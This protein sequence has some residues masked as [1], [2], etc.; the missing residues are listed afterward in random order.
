MGGGEV[1]AGAS[2]SPAACSLRCRKMENWSEESRHGLCILLT[3]RAASPARRCTGASPRRV[4]LDG[5]PLPLD[6]IAAAYPEPNQPGALSAS[7]AAAAGIS[8]DSGVT[9]TIGS[10]DCGGLESA[11]E[12]VATPSPSPV[13]AA[14]PAPRRAPSAERRRSTRTAGGHKAGDYTA[15]GGTA[16]GV[17]F[18]AAATVNVTG[19][20]EG[21]VSR[22]RNMLQTSG[23]NKF[24]YG[25]W[26]NV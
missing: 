7:A 26:S 20:A 8:R 12:P 22:R 14:R 5:A 2:T 15:A 18:M 19:D 11:P 24:Y 6:R 25:Q 10:L 23:S 1:R 13:P 21:I 9:A 3:W 16:L 4:Q 17:Q